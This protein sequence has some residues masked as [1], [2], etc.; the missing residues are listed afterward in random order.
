[1]VHFAPAI[2]TLYMTN[3]PAD[4]PRFLSEFSIDDAAR[5]AIMAQVLSHGLGKFQVITDVQYRL[6]LMKE[7]QAA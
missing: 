4:E 6:E 3:V 1:M 5:R 7:E 2:Y